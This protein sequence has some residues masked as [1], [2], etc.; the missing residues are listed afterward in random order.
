M[1]RVIRAPFIPL[2]TILLACFG[3]FALSSAGAFESYQKFGDSFYFARGQLL[4]GVIPGIVFMYAVYRMAPLEWLRTKTFFLFAAAVCLLVF[5]WIP[6]LRA[7]FGTAHSWILV[8]G[9]SV[10]PSEFAKLALVLFFASWLARTSDEDIRSWERGFIPFVCFL[11][12]LLGLL[13]IQPDLGTAILYAAIA[14]ALL[15]VRG[16]PYA[17]FGV[18]GV[19]GAG[20]LL[21]AVMMAPYRIAR[22]TTFLDPGADTQGVG[23][24]IH[25]AMIALGSGGVGGLGYGHSRQKFQYL[26]EVMGDSIFAIIGEEFGFLICALLIIAF[27]VFFVY[28][29]RRARM[30]QD[31]YHRLIVVGVAVWLCGQAYINIGAMLGVFPLTG[32]PLPLLSHGGSAVWALCIGLGMT[33]CAI[34]EGSRQSRAPSLRRI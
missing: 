30:I 5:V 8:F 33:W 11:G 6:G 2:A 26:P 22:L 3:V 10:Q 23:Y 12:V 15:F 9:Q 4:Y 20:I 13:F 25:Q 1:R 34:E 14:C 27:S 29:L 24:H 17:F 18:L 16:A 7:P 31:M 21:F 32:V 28:Q 19:C